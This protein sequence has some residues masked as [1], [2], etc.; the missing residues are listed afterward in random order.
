[1]E[2]I[3]LKDNPHPPSPPREKFT[4]RLYGKKLA[5]LT[6]IN[7]TALASYSE[8]VLWYSWPQYP[9]PGPQRFLLI[10]LHEIEVFLNFSQLLSLI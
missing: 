3:C 4:E 2:K 5:Q 10:F 7:L 9:C 6:E 8:I 1:M